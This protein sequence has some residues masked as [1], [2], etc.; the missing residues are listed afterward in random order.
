MSSPTLDTSPTH[1]DHTLQVPSVPAFSFK[2]RLPTSSSSQ[3]TSSTATG[4]KQRR[5]SLAL[6]SST[7]VA[8]NFR[9]DT[10]VESHVPET[11][12]SD[13]VPEKWRK[14]RKIA[15]LGDNEVPHEKKQRKK[16]SDEETQMLVTGCNI[17]SC[18][19]TIIYHPWPHSELSTALA[20]GRQSS[21]ILI[22]SLTT[23]RQ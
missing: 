5:V 2:A 6:P 13:L 22:S 16:W 7:R 14:M 21:V 19:D 3:S 15:P 18:F 17:V 8:W 4:L 1:G 23:V 9:D 10:G 20:T 12:A 11:G